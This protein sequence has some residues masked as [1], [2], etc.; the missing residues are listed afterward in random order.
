MRLVPVDHDPFA[1]TPQSAGAGAPA[2]P[3][4]QPV[5]HDPFAVSPN[6]DATQ[7]MRGG[8]AQG[9]AQWLGGPADFAGLIARGAD[10][11]RSKITGQPIEQ[12]AAEADA[13]ALVPRSSVERFGSEAIGGAMRSNFAASNPGQ[14]D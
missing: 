5:D 9:V 13:N 10:R 14:S 11:V 4:L 6:A 7:S 3:R 1:A 2:Q 8:F 12:V